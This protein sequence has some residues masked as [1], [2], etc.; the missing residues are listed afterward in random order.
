MTYNLLLSDYILHLQDETYRD[1]MQHVTWPHTRM[2][3]QTQ[4][5][6]SS[7]PLVI[8]LQIMHLYCEFCIT[9]YYRH[10]AA[11]HLQLYWLKNNTQPSN[12]IHLEQQ[13]DTVQW[14]KTQRYHTVHQFTK[15]QECWIQCT[16]RREITADFSR[17]L[18]KNKWITTAVKYLTGLKKQ[19]CKP[20]VSGLLWVCPAY[21]R[22]LCPLLRISLNCKVKQLL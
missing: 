7:P 15:K 17:F 9:M 5:L 13:Q 16:E 6:R 8:Q 19:T 12:Y 4:R 10:K 18:L 1:K 3:A 2:A 21:Q 11:Q 22:H 20:T 14:A